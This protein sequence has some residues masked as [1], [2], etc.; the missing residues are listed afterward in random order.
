MIHT[1][2]KYLFKGALAMDEMGVIDCVVTPISI[3][4]KPMLLPVHIKK[5]AFLIHIATDMCL[6][7]DKE[8]VEEF[9]QPLFE[10]Q[11]L[12][13]KNNVLIAF[14]KDRLAVL[15]SCLVW[16]LFGG[17]AVP[18]FDT[19]ETTLRTLDNL[20]SI[21]MNGLSGDKRAV[22]LSTGLAYPEL[23]I[24]DQDWSLEEVIVYGL[25]HGRL[26]FSDE[27][28]VFDFPK[29]NRDRMKEMINEVIENES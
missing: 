25:V 2:Q 12:K 11:K 8:G 14:G 27:K 16:Q 15:E 9:L 20:L 17:I 24:L 7:F 1:S 28:D 3:P 6:A 10:M 23:G 13:S 21:P 26:P 22:Q 18:V 19:V 29:L 4:L 5:N